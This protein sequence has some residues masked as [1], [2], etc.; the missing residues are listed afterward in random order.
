MPYFNVTEEL[1]KK[2]AEEVPTLTTYEPHASRVQRIRTSAGDGGGATTY[3]ESLFHLHFATQGSVRTPHGVLTNLR[4]SRDHPMG[5]RA[6]VDPTSPT[7]W[8]EAKPA[9]EGPGRVVTS[10]RPA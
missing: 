1:A 9:H 6:H 7:R 8:I 5:P 2:L 4:P 3:D 10:R